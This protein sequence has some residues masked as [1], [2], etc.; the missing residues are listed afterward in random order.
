MELVPSPQ[1]HSDCT[2]GQNLAGS[3][4]TLVDILDMYDTRLFFP[5]YWQSARTKYTYTVSLHF[6]S[7]GLNII[8]LLSGLVGSVLYINSWIPP[9]S[10]AREPTSC[11]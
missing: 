4:H 1:A 9:V 7:T 6:M 5:H 11:D 2:S 3:F 8:P 10:T